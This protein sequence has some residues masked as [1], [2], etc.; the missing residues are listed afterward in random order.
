MLL[1]PL[2]AQSHLWQQ[3][4]AQSRQYPHLNP[5]FPGLAAGAIS[6]PAQPKPKPE[7]DLMAEHKALMERF[8]SSVNAAAIA[9]AAA[10]Q[11][12]AAAQAASSSEEERKEEKPKENQSLPMDLSKREDEEEDLDVVEESKEIEDDLTFKKIVIKSDLNR[13]NVVQDKPSQNE[14]NNEM[15]DEQ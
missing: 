11:A 14:S 1:S 8:A 15:D 12:A 6:P 2:L 10:Q 13:N 9:A 3:M 5:L 4:A 7:V